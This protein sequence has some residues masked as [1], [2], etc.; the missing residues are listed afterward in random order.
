MYGRLYKWNE[1]KT[2]CPSG[3]HL[4]SNANWGDLV[5]AVGGNSDAGTKL[6]STSGWNNWSGATSGNGTDN[7]GFSALPGGDRN[8]GGNFCCAGQLGSWWTAGERDTDDA[9]RRFMFYNELI[10]LNGY[11]SKEDGYSVR[12]VGD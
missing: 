2:V 11:S 12:C 3:W 4:S 8:T 6:K 1:A 5:T 9:Y 7:F 10:V